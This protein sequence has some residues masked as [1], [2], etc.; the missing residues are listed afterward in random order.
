MMEF[1][2]IGG[3]MVILIVAFIAG[4]FFMPELFGISKSKEEPPM[5]SDSDKVGHEPSSSVQAI[6]QDDDV[7]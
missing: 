4:M 5:K 6:K 2:I 7:S 3:F 1:F